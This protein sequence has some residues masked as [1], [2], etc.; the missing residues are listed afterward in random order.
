ELIKN[1]LMEGAQW[2]NEAF[3]AAGFKDAFQVKVLPADAD[4]SDIRYNVVQWVHRST[5]GWS[6]GSSIMDPRTGEILKGEVT[7]DSRRVRQDY[8]IVQGL[9][10]NFDALQD[11]DSV[12]TNMALN[13]IK[14][15]SAHELGNTLGLAHNFIGSIYNRAS[16]MDYPA[17]KVDIVEG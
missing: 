6:Y 15:L 1:A 4:P 12:L 16:V 2:W 13:R 3:E 17:P 9:K 10:G 14:Q 8:L 7:L 11:D 5:R